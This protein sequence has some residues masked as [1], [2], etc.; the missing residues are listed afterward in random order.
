MTDISKEE[1]REMIDTLH[2]MAIAQ[3]T[4]ARLLFQL[5]ELLRSVDIRPANPD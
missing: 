1:K 3:E 5:L 4:T 2:R